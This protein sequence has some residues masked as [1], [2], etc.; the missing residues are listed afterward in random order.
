M[1]Q[2]DDAIMNGINMLKP[3]FCE[4]SETTK[5]PG[6]INRKPNIAVQ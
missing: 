3:N 5:S 4:I 1:A 6:G 2:S